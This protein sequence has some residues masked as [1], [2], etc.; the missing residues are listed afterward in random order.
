MAFGNLVSR[1]PEKTFASPGPQRCTD[2]TRGGGDVFYVER[3][4]NPSDDTAIERIAFSIVDRFKDA[5][6]AIGKAKDDVRT[7]RRNNALTLRDDQ[8]FR[9]CLMGGRPQNLDEGSQRRARCALD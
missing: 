3:R 4:T 7:S 1:D 8:P 2:G 5:D 6:G 9:L